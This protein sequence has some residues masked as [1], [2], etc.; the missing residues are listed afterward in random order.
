MPNLNTIA[1]QSAAT[2]L[3]LGSAPLWQ[4]ALLDQPW[5]GAIIALLIFSVAAFMLRSSSRPKLALPIAGLGVLAATAIMIVGSLITTTDAM[6]RAQTIRFVDA[7]AGADPQTVDELLAPRFVVASTGAPNLNLGKD[8][9][10][11]ITSGMDSAI[12]S[13]S[14]SIVEVQRQTNNATVE[15][16][17][18]TAVTMDSQTV[19]STWQVQ[20]Q[21][22]E[23]Q[24]HAGWK[25][26]RLEAKSIFGQE[27]GNAWIQWGNRYRS[28]R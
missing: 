15:F 23:G 6:L 5:I 4:T 27:P 1:N 12:R 8:W 26:I 18:K 21:R 19:N 3:T 22:F 20:W 17:C 24:G 11:A 14:V 13:N 16:R 9:L 10:I 2:P 25:I 7:I 28:N